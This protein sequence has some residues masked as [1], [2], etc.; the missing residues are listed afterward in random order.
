M[1]PVNNY[2]KLV[3]FVYR[4]ANNTTIFVTSV[5]LCILTQTERKHTD[6]PWNLVHLSDL[7]GHIIPFFLSL[8]SDGLRFVCSMK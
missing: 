8:T 7:S 4:I 2:M 1:K 6:Q 5:K 3:C